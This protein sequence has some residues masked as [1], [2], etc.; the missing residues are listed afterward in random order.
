[1]SKE[2]ENK[3]RSQ[4]YEKVGVSPDEARLISFL[5]IL[6]HQSGGKITIN[7]LSEYANK[8]FALDVEFDWDNDRVHV[9][10]IELPS[11]K[12]DIN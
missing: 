1:M 7:R 12:E 4:G 2:F 10:S 9:N 11:A 6:I 3:M 5:S 8:Q